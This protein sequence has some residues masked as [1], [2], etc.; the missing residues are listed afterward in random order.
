MRRVECECEECE[1]KSGSSS[2]TFTRTCSVQNG[3][4]QSHY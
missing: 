4:Q 3:Q 1:V 2:R